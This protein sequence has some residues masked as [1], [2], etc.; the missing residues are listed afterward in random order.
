ME[1]ESLHAQHRRGFWRTLA[2]AGI[3]AVPIGF[4]VGFGIGYGDPDTFWNWAPDWLVLLL[5]G[6]AVMTLLYASWRFWRSV[7]EVERLDNL[8]GSAM[9]YGVYAMLFP[10]WWVL[11]KSG[12]TSEPN[13]WTIFV[14]ALVAGMA[15]YFGR[16][17]RAR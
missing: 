16:K 6:V 2:I 14:V 8:W 13:D 4:A 12:M 11:A 15:F 10:A 9:A 1:G 5:L 17:W 7:D 3:G